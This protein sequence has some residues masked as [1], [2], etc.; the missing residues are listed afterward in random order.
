[1]SDANEGDNTHN[2]ECDKNTMG[3]LAQLDI[4]G[5]QDIYLTGNPQFSYFTTA[6]PP[7][8]SEDLVTTNYLQQNL[9]TKYNTNNKIFRY[10]NFTMQSIENNKSTKVSLYGHRMSYLIER[11]G[12]IV[13]DMSVKILLPVLPEDYVYNNYLAFNIIKNVEI[14]IGGQ[15][16]NK[17]YGDFNYFYSI[18]T[19]QIPTTRNFESRSLFIS[20]DP[21]IRKKWS[22]TANY[23]EGREEFIEIVVPLKSLLNY[24][25]LP[26]VSLQYHEVKINFEIEKSKNLI[27]YMPDKKVEVNFDSPK[28]E[29]NIHSV[30]ILTD[31]IY[32][33]RPERKHLAQVSNEKLVQQ[34]Q[35]TGGEI[36]KSGEKKIKLATNFNHPITYLLITFR[37]IDSEDKGIHNTDDP[38]GFGYGVVGSEE[39]FKSLEIILKPLDGTDT[40]RNCVT[41]PTYFR[42]Y[43]PNKHL[44]LQ[45]GLPSGMY[46]YSYSL[47]NPFDVQ[48]SGSCNYSRL[49]RGD[50]II[51]F[52]KQLIKKRLEIKVFG[53]ANQVIRIMSGM[54]G[55]AHSK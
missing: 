46:F 4:F 5:A 29:H 36:K 2:Q 51:K 42:N 24:Y 35:F 13:T 20:S 30:S 45:N 27:T 21:E 18:M 31:Y 47:K 10:T 8:K 33:D 7:T 39:C 19:K 1:M 9:N 52:Q 28:C 37:E 12:D 14:E 55:L 15:R 50:I 3:P 41:N 16:I 22:K 53:G 48:P 40:T 54:A 26:L 6:F 23:Y 17:S 25:D 49:D 43:L 44:G 11:N 34:T 38:N 32:L